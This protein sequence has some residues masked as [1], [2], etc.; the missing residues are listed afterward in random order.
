MKTLLIPL[1]PFLACG[2]ITDTRVEVT[3]TQAIIR[4][5]APDISA[6]SMEVSE[7]AT[8]SPLVHDIDS[9]LFSGANLDSRVGNVANGTERVFVV[10]KRSADLASDGMRYSRALQQNTT[11]YY[12]I[13]C[14]AD[15]AT[16]S[17]HT[18]HFAVGSTY[19]EPLPPDPDNPGQYSYPTIDWSQPTNAATPG[20]TMSTS[21]ATV[22]FSGSVPTTDLEAG[23][24]LFINSGPQA[25]QSRRV[26]SRA[27]STHATLG[28]SFQVNQSAGTDWL[29]R[30]PERTNT[31][32][33]IDPKTGFLIRRITGPHQGYRYDYASSGT[34]RIDTVTPGTG[35]SNGTVGAITSIDSN[36][37]TFSGGCSPT[38]PWLVMHPAS[39]ASP[40]TVYDDE[41][42]QLNAVIVQVAGS[43][44]GTGDD[45]KLQVCLSAD[46]ATCR[47]VV[48]EVDMSG[49]SSTCYLGDEW[50]VLKYWITGASDV[51]ASYINRVEFFGAKGA[52]LIRKKTAN[53]AISIDY[54]GASYVFGFGSGWPTQSYQIC[55]D[56]YDTQIYKG[57]TRTGYRCLFYST[58]GSAFYFIDKD[59]GDSAP[60]SVNWVA[61]GS[62]AGG[63]WP[64]TALA[65]SAQLGWNPS[66]PR[67]VYG[68]SPRVGG[69]TNILKSTYIGNNLD[70]GPFS[71]SNPPGSYLQSV[72]TLTQGAS[73]ESKAE[74]FLTGHSRIMRAAEWSGSC[75]SAQVVDDTYMTAGCFLNGQDTGYGWDLVIGLSG[76]KTGEIVAAR[77]THSVYPYRFNTLHSWPSRRVT[78]GWLYAGSNDLASSN[79]CT[80]GPFRTELAAAMSAPGT[81][82]DVACPNPLPT[83]KTGNGVCT[84]VK[85]MGDLYKPSTSCSW[86]NTNRGDP[87]SGFLDMQAARAGDVFKIDSERVQVVAKDAACS[88]P[89]APCA[90]TFLRGIDNSAPAA[91][92]AGSNV[93]ASRANSAQFF[94][95]A[96]D[97]YGEGGYRDGNIAWSYTGHCGPVLNQR[98]GCV[99]TTTMCH[100]PNYPCYSIFAGTIPEISA[101][102]A[103]SAS[104]YASAAAQQFA[105]VTGDPYSSDSHLSY[106]QRTGEAIGWM[107]DSFPESGPQLSGQTWNL[108]AGSTSLY[109]TTFSPLKQR[110][111]EGACINRALV[112]VTPGPIV[113]G[114]AG[115]Y[116][117]CTGASCRA[118]ATSGVAFVNCPDAVPATSKSC[119]LSAS[120]DASQICLYN[121]SSMAHGYRQ[122]WIDH[123]DPFGS[124]ERNLGAFFQHHRMSVDAYTTG[125]GTF[126]GE[127]MFFRTRWADGIRSDVY[128]LHLGESPPTDSVNRETF[129]PVNV[130]IHGVPSGA[131]SVVAEFGYDANFRC[132]HRPEACE[133]VGPVVNEASPFYYASEAFSGQSCTSGCTVAMPALSQRVLYYRLKYLDEGGSVVSTTSPLVAVTP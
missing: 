12:R 121:T 88:D 119:T 40:A 127:W 76:A 46:G 82:Q 50:P 56:N 106:Q 96:A 132:T 2:A 6:C 74:T 115:E 67:V 27:D 109:S 25:G 120:P 107:I 61:A 129:Q 47:S 37:A 124:W 118:G 29:R 111:T 39:S 79:V 36:V 110:P 62:D 97:P 80:A 17:F 131:T 75:T 73:L 58:G 32:Q 68:S 38:C 1:L 60:T 5:T 3:N 94:N 65:H 87:P 98:M 19:N 123:I 48:H 23:D 9:S 66:D 114:T 59:T 112:D 34:P 18:A 122:V 72:S 70:M 4:Y 31:Q 100:L 102:Y 13:T 117:F 42:K 78:G 77:S 53:N 93:T 10:G 63:G 64:T 83:N 7:S 21:G 108:V 52:I 57:T 71:P 26:A 99:T 54:V 20:V 8:Y 15:A 103:N 45:A 44:T 51:A 104:A 89:N 84:Q 85:V 116:T 128:A 130:Q 11:H 92:N 91:H 101:Q 69:G 41:E 14:G 33:I 55:S 28:T 30:T 105:G 35:W 90:W 113:D 22:T 49:C 95:Y 16:G 24:I 43:A 125:V 126:D 133:A 81:G 86:E